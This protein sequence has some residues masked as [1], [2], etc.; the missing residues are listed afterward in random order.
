MQGPAVTAPAPVA[1]SRPASRPVPTRRVPIGRRATAQAG[2]VPAQ[3]SEG[4]GA[5]GPDDLE[6]LSA[7]DESQ[8]GEVADFDN[9]VESRVLKAFPGAEEVG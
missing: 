5:E 9:S 1:A 6:D 3:A 7:F 2:G 4:S 8:L